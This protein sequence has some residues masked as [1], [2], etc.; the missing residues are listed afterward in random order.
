MKLITI[1]FLLLSIILLILNRVSGNTS[2]QLGLNTGGS[3]TKYTTG[4]N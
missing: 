4:N 1:L 3:S 2:T